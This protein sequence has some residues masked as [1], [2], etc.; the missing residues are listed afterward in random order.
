M[1]DLAIFHV[2]ATSEQT[3]AQ[4]NYE[5]NAVKIVMD[6]ICFEKSRTF[7]NSNA[8]TIEVLCIINY[9][10]IG[11]GLSKVIKRF[12]CPNYIKHWSSS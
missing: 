11:Y 10:I 12:K 7:L 9:T 2:T 4:K 5:R 1:I 3:V 6:V 8:I